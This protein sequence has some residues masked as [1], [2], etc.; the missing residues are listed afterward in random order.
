M[1]PPQSSFGNGI[2]PNLEIQPLTSRRLELL[3]R[4]NSPALLAARLHFGTA[5]ERDMQ[6][7]ERLKN[8]AFA[9]ET[10]TEAYILCAPFLELDAIERMTGEDLRAAAFAAIPELDKKNLDALQILIGHIVGSGIKTFGN[11]FLIRSQN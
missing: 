9:D 6:D 10:R 2:P 8:N 3:Q 11:K 1:N 4:M 5:N 7:S